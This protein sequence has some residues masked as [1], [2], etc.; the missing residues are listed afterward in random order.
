MRDTQGQ[1]DFVVSTTLPEFSNSTSVVSSIRMPVTCPTACCLVE[2]RVPPDK[3]V[4]G[5]ICPC[6]MHMS[7]AVLPHGISFPGAI[8]KA[9]VHYQRQGQPE[10]PPPFR[11]QNRT[12]N[13]TQCHRLRVET[14]PLWV[15]GLLG[16]GSSWAHT[17]TRTDINANRRSGT[18][19]GQQLQT[20]PVG[21]P[22]GAAAVEYRQQ[23][24]PALSTGTG[25]EFTLSMTPSKK[26]PDER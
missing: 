17:P 5:H 22:L 23:Y 20:A 12:A 18:C 14:L 3:E 4:A 8:W 7:H 2:D 9:L 13:H 10:S 25:S 6:P 24:A 15:D 1:P 21:L 19:N 26:D 16:E 11:F